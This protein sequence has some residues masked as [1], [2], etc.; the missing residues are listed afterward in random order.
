VL[1]SKWRKSL[2]PISFLSKSPSIP[3]LERGEVLETE[4][5]Q[6]DGEKRDCTGGEERWKGLS[7]FRRGNAGR[8]EG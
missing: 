1:K 4:A 8:P 3:P 5:G 6:P 7:P 2:N